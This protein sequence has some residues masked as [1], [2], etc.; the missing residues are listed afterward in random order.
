MSRPLLETKR[1]WTP[2]VLATAANVRLSCVAFKCG[3]HVPSRLVCF[4]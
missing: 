1:G 2:E 3:R 4:H